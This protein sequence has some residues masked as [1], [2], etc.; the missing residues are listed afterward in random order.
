MANLSQREI[1]YLIFIGSTGMLLLIG[2]IAVFIAVYQRKMI[3]NRELHRKVEEYHQQRMIQLQFESQEGE[4][5]RIAADLHDS[6][7]SLLWGAKLTAA[8]IERSSQVNES[9]KASHKE[10]MEIL[11]QSIQTVKRIAWEIAP[12]AF[13]YSGLSQSLAALCLRFDGKGLNVQFN[14]HGQTIL[15]NDDRALQVYRIVQELVSN[16]VRHAQA[17]N[18]SVVLSWM[19]GQLNIEVTDDGIGFNLEGKREGIGWWNINHRINQLHAKIEIGVPPMGK[20][21]IMNL[22][23]PLS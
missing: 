13:H 11:D 23:I 21:S 8:Y 16:C 22:S 7:G 14:E 5:K 17:A 3:T 19:P 9:Q 18:L 6:V 4:R 12:E 10:L 20:G 1:I 15:W 2:G